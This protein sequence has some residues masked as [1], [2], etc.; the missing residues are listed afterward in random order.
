M[1]EQQKKLTGGKWI[2]NHALQ[3][4][5]LFLILGGALLTYSLQGHR[6]AFLQ[7]W[8]QSPYLFPLFVAVILGILACSLLCQGMGKTEGW[9]SGA[10]PGMD[11]VAESL[12]VSSPA[13]PSPAAMH[14]LAVLAMSLLYYLTLGCLK[15]P[16]ITFWFLSWPLLTVSNFEICTL[17]FLTVFM[18]YLGVGRALVLTAVPLGT[19]VF[20]SVVFRA[21]LHVLLP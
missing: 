6:Q 15:I 5:I 17:V 2:R 13:A 16:Y 10:A 3:E 1:L 9:D 8:S 12:E 18:R 21:V 20:L 14:I 4:G 11:P 7:D 19:T